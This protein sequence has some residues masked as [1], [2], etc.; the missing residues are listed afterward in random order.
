MNTKKELII[1]S[2]TKLFGERG[3]ENTSVSQICV[4]AK[5]SKGLVYHHFKTKDDLLREIFSDTTDRMIE[6]S[7]SSETASEPREKLVQL[8]QQLFLQLRTDKSFFQLNLNI[9]LQPGTRSILNDLIKERSKYILESVK[10]IFKDI[11]P[12]NSDVLSYMFIAELDGIAI[13]FLTVFDE[14][15]I[16]QL[17]KHLIS[18]YA[19]EKAS[20]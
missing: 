16:E 8:I 13:D 15:P 9:M 12:S 17:E 10:V 7:K 1:N 6:I 14:Y 2:A 11:D 19:N 3:F 20:D 18:K 5:V 4:E